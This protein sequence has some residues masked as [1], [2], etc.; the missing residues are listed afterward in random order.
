MANG[1]VSET[2]SRNKLKFTNHL[3]KHCLFLLKIKS[4]KLRTVFRHRSLSQGCLVFLFF[5]LRSNVYS[6]LVAI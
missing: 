1:P 2:K 5:H 6:T 3:S 4:D